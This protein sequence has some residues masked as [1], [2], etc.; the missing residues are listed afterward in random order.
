[1]SK[2]TLAQFPIKLHITSLG[3]DADA[4]L[5]A[6]DLLKLSKFPIY[7]YASGYVCSAG[8]YLFL[9][10]QKRFM[11]Q[12][13]YFLI[14]H[15]SYDVSG[16]HNDISDHYN[17]NQIITKNIENLYLDETKLDKNKIRELLKREKIMSSNEC[18]RYGIV[19]KILK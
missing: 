8:T 1:M 6:Y 14:H 11:T 19:N 12:N 3:G 2:N 4:G 5:M 16:K 18:L 13:S 17:N 10:G 9:T 15:L 7:T